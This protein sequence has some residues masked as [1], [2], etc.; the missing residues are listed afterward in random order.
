MQELV[1]LPVD[2][3]DVHGPGMQIDSAVV[4]G[5][6]FVVFHLGAYG[7]GSRWVA[8]GQLALNGSPCHPG[9]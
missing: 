8:R 4:F 3:A 2:E 5:G 6:G 9:L 1:A 7:L